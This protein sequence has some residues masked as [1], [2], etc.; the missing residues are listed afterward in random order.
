MNTAAA[1][2]VQAAHELI[3]KVSSDLRQEDRWNQMLVG[4]YDNMWK[5]LEMNDVEA[6]ADWLR[7]PVF[8]HV[9]LHYSSHLI[10]YEM[11]MMFKYAAMLNVDVCCFG[12]SR[13]DPT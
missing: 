6:W 3:E 9:I 12:P 10:T 8:F 4:Q 7:S 13:C 1:R 2:A 5:C 11:F